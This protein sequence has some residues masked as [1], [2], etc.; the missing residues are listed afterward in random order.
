VEP[1]WCKKKREDV[2]KGRDIP[3]VENG[4]ESG[5][6]EGQAALRGS[7]G[8]GVGGQRVMVVAVG[9]RLAYANVEET[10]RSRTHLRGEVGRRKDRKNEG[11]GGREKGAKCRK[12]T[13]V[14]EKLGL[15]R[16]LL[17]A[18]EK[19]RNKYRGA[20]NPVK[21]RGW[22]VGAKGNAIRGEKQKI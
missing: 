6:T 8:V 18:R 12:D 20:Y 10:R 15:K 4:L 9:R 17:S 11:G 19:G 7:E 21:T 14:P 2:G 22:C 13:C 16:Y 5:T 1:D 3:G